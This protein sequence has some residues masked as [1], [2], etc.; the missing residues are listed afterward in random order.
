M[1]AARIPEQTHVMTIAIGKWALTQDSGFPFRYY[2]PAGPGA[3][4]S[5]ANPP[6]AEPSTALL[7]SNRAHANIPTNSL[8]GWTGVGS[9]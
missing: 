5:R 3:V 6:I 9:H 7:V 8:S 2:D 4:A 1:D